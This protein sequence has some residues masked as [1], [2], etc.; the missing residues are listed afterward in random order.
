MQ[1]LLQSE[2]DA[3]EDIGDC[4]D[5]EELFPRWEEYLAEV[6]DDDEIGSVFAASDSDQT[7]RGWE[8]EPIPQPDKTPYP[9]VDYPNFPQ[10]NRIT[11]IRALKSPLSALFSPS[12]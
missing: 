6:F 1:P 9:A 11:G 5:A 10:E 7:Y 2:D 3:L 4:I 12:A 8:F